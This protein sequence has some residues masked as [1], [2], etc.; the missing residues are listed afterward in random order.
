MAG[1]TPWELT[2]ICCET[3]E[4]VDLEVLCCLDWTTA[5][6][7]RFEGEKVENNSMAKV[8]WVCW[9]PVLRC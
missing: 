1:S 2:W 9:L 3:R 5:P 6:E 4:V 7:H 8:I